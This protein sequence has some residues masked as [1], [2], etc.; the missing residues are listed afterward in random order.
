MR[1]SAAIGS[2]PR[3]LP[4]IAVLLAASAGIISSTSFADRAVRTLALHSLESTA[5]GIS[6][7]AEQVLKTGDGRSVQFERLFS[8]R[9]VAYAL[10]ASADGTVLFHTNP[11]LR[12]T[13]FDDKDAFSRLTEGAAASRRALLGTGR[14]VL[15]YDRL[16][17]RQEGLP[18]LLRLALHTV[19]TD[20]MTARVENLWWS[21][22]AVLLLLWAGGL[23]VVVLA[24]RSEKHRRKAER[25]E[26]LALIGQMTSTLA[27]EIRNAIGSV[28]GYA[29]LAAEG[30]DAGDPRAR[31]LATVLRGVARIE[32]LVGDLLL[33]SREERFTVAEVDPALL[34]SAAV[35]S[36][37]PWTGR[38]ELDLEPGLRVRADVEKLERVI[39]NGVHN[40]LQA[41]GGTGLLGVSLRRRGGLAEIR[42]EDTG[43]GIP[44]EALPK[45]FTPFYTTRATGTGLGLAYAK[46]VVEGMGGSVTLENREAA[47][48][49][50]FTVLLPRA[51]G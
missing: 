31:Q 12:G 22:G 24:A 35:S 27:H 45:L 38:V 18:V 40:A 30:T 32:Q 48:G 21:V 15:L 37:A 33:F 47:A 51:G 16:L 2:A 41:M 3:A 17:P 13:P 49:A 44:P 39:T 26:S 19:E 20:R 46:K 14:P 4:V 34:L 7:A 8:E 23:L 5:R 29:Q 28:K 6:L 50:V 9:I 42:I 43:G 11:E 25:G 1:R 10:I 36:I